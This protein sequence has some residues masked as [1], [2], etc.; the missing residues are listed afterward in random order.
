M[1]PT[2]KLDWT[3]AHPRM[4]AAPQSEAPMVGTR[5]GASTCHATGA[6]CDR[7]NGMGGVRS[8]DCASQTVR[9]CGHPSPDVTSLESPK[10]PDPSVVRESCVFERGLF[11]RSCIVVA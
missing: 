10:C 6:P 5:G 3:G 11:V 4:R 1:G 2:P 8:C 9:S 7:S